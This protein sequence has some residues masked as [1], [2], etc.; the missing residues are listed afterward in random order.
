VALPRVLRR[1]V[2]ETADALGVAVECIAT[3]AMAT[4]ASAIGNTC[5][6]RINPT[7]MEPSILWAVVLME[8]GSL[9]TP[10]YKAAMEPL[11][12]AQ[13]VYEA[14]FERDK[15]A[16]RKD[17][18][19]YEA[20]ANFWRGQPADDNSP[21]PPTAPVA[22]RPVD[23]FTSD[24]TVEALGLLFANN[25]RGLALT[26][27]ELSAFFGSFGAYKGGRGADEAT[28]LE[29]YNAAPV[30]VN[31]ASGKRIYVPSAALTIFGTCQPAVFLRAIG[32]HGHG[33]NQVENGLAARFIIAAPE[34]R[35]K[36]WRES[37]P[38]ETR[39]YHAM[40]AKLLAVPLQRNAE[41][42]I[43]PVNI[44]L[45]PEGQ[46]RF[47]AFVTEHGKHGHSIENPPL[48]YHYAKLEAIAA[49][50]ALIF[51]QCDVAT[52]DLDEGQG[53]Q[54]RHVLAGI[55]IVR[56]YGREAWRV[57]E[58]CESS[59]EREMRALVEKIS[60]YGGVIRVRDMRDMSRKWR[61]SLAAD[62]ALKTLESYGYGEF[63]WEN[64]GPNGGRPSKLFRL[65]GYPDV[66]VTVASSEPAGV[67]RTGP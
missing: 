44:E 31:R 13:Q 48:R 62:M 43:E 49:R 11:R 64:A 3:P 25:P 28:Y 20:D 23:L 2:E 10:A 34:P 66:P 4:C 8:S 24:S 22:P 38:F 33:S 37:K 35:P 63:F 6:I 51:Y 42:R 16:Y 50:L 1:F 41:G 57:Y 46:K 32:V 29:F 12:L 9:K 5:R 60:E 19:D 45:R 18:A 52:G 39:H 7:W 26:R 61:D 67:T 58:G 65:H 59:E 36:R 55:A 54:D 14:E 40:I 21:T 27:D 53:V 47:A 17:K 15:E 56:W 30:K